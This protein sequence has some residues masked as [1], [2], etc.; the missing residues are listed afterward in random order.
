[1]DG[2]AYVFSDRKIDVNSGYGETNPTDTQPFVVTI[3]DVKQESSQRKDK[4]K[5][6]VSIVVRTRETVHV[7]TLSEDYLNM[8]NLLI[9]VFLRNKEKKY[10]KK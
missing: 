5:D 2:L 7:T 3:I 4:T 8:L 6:G 10:F 1:M 9:C